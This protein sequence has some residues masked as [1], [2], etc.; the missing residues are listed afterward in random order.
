MRNG[1]VAMGAALELSV[2]PSGPIRIKWVTLNKQMKV[3][4]REEPVDRTKTSVSTDRR[5][6]GF[7]RGLSTCPSGCEWQDRY[8]LQPPQSPSPRLLTRPW[9][10]HAGQ[11]T[12]W[13]KYL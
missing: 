8:F 13:C 9:P 5:Q 2:V 7:P 10:R 3:T 4:W 12:S 1:P 6:R 11:L